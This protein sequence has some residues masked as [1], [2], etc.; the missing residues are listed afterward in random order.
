MIEPFSFTSI[1]MRIRFGSGA[2]STLPAE[3][4]RHGISRALV[5]CSPTRTGTAQRV[6]EPIA[7]ARV[8]VCAKAMPNMPR[9]AYE[10]VVA[11]LRANQANGFVVIGGGS[12]IGLAK[13]VAANTALPYVAIVTTYSGSEMSAGW[14]LGVGAD[15]VSGN[16]PSA[17]PATTIYDPDLT[18]D[19]PAD[20][21]AAS[22]MNAMAH[23][24]ETLYGPD[25]D[26]VTATLAEEA[27]RRLGTALPEIVR[28]PSDAAA[29]SDALYGAWLAGAYRATAGLEHALAQRVRQWF[30]LD[31][32]RTHAVMLPYAVGF[33]RRHA[34]AAMAVIERALGVG[35]AA[36]GL[37]QMNIRLRLPTGLKDLGLRKDDIMKA[38]A[39]V[40]AAKFPNPRP[41]STGDLLDL[42]TAAYGGDPPP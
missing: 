41:V 24:V 17:L 3:L 14:Y 5:L 31:H 11:E 36:Q 8:A 35:D 7:D 6:T 18:L 30:G 16:D 15:R 23:A 39:V 13:A 38:A 33:N 4:E 20:M 40:A 22:G 32:A 19:L 27:I 12:P 25:L 42:I 21:S 28:D 29:R 10:A 34:P 26:P 9:D 37:Y 1:P 2:V